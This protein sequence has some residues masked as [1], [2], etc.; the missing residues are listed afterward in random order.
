MPLDYNNAKIYKIVNDIDD[1]IYIGSTCQRLS[2]R[3]VGHRV[4]ANKQYKIKLYEHMNELGIDHF[5][6]VLIKAYKCENIEQLQKK[7]EFYKRRL[8]PSLNDKI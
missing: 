7:E 4:Q 5:K 3:M 8:K 6:I 1:E 2:M